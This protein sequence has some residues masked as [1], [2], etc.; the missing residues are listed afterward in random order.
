[1]D[2]WSFIGLCWKKIY[3]ETA[4]SSRY[5][6]CNQISEINWTTAKVIALGRRIKES[7]SA[8]P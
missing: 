4:R 3:R 8:G 5:V 1:V 6:G 2:V 7:V